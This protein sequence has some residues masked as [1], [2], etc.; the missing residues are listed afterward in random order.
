MIFIELGHTFEVI[1]FRKDAIILTKKL[2]I[3]GFMLQSAGLFKPYNSAGV[4]Q[5]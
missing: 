3:L 4:N 1:S 2:L 5:N